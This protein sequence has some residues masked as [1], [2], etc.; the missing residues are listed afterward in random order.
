MYNY[1]S[2]MISNFKKSYTQKEK[3]NLIWP[4]EFD[5]TLLLG[6]SANSKINPQNK[7]KN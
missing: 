7:L 5:S 2:D 1:V 6:T 4:D 3:A